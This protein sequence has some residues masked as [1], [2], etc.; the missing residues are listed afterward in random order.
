MKQLIEYLAKSLVENPEAVRVTEQRL[1]DSMV[2]ELK[3]ANEDLGRI[4]GQKGQTVKAIRQLLTAAA[5][6]TKTKVS[7]IVQE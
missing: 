4:I 1:N 5:T 7:L 3:V 2:L 6:K